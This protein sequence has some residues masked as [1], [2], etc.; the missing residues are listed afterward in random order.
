M[1]NLL[2]RINPVSQ[3]NVPTPIAG[4][5]RC[6]R[7]L[8]P[9][10]KTVAFT[11]RSPARKERKCSRTVECSNIVEGNAWL[12]GCGRA[13][14]VYM[15]DTTFIERDVIAA[16]AGGAGRTPLSWSAA[17]AGAFTATAIAFLVIAL[18]SGIGLSF[19]SPYGSGPS[20]TALT[21][22]AAVW[23][24]MAHALGFAT[25]GYLAGRLRSPA[26]DGVV[27]ET[28]FRDAAEGLMVWAIGVVVM[29]AIAGT[30]ALFSAGAT[31]HVAA[32]AAAGSGMARN[33]QSAAT[34]TSATD[35]FV[36]LM[37]RPQADS[38]ATA[39]QTPGTVG[40]G[41][42]GEARPAL[43]NETRAEMTRIV[44]RSLTQAQIDTNDKAYLA[45]VVSART[46]LPPDEAQRRVDDVESKARESVKQAADTA[47]KAGAMFSFWTFMALLFGGAAAT[48]AG[49]LGGQLRDEEGRALA[50]R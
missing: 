45:Q 13:K 12:P 30:L 43:D 18:G 27:G 1:M 7:W 50:S 25:G 20:A 46:G 33:D 26:H 24:V 9:Q 4:T 31:A 42:T 41:S 35:Y 32:G 16:A 14:G 48:L 22:V 3:E 17:I 21:A 19:A 39:G 38:A 8:L 5:H 49:I 28:T 44:T 11:L 36:D 6:S 15:A 37:F 47:A 40:A 29:A 10:C 23:L 34:T 2:D